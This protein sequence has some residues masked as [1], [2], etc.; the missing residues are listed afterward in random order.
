[1]YHIYAQLCYDIDIEKYDASM[2]LFLDIYS[3][4]PTISI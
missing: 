4:V 2:L 1:M 3:A